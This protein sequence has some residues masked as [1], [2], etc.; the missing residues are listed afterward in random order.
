VGV[1]GRKEP[2]EGEI[3]GGS[4]VEV[5]V[6]RRHQ[7]P[8]MPRRTGARVVG[9]T[10]LLSLTVDELELALAHHAL[11]SADRDTVSSEKMQIIVR[12]FVPRGQLG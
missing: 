6:S 7:P 11:R 9:W 12:P 8:P 5:V 1:D 4:R 10:G 2:S 3:G